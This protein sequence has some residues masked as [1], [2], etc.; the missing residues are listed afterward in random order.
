MVFMRDVELPLIFLGNF[1]QIIMKYNTAEINLFLL[2]V[3]IDKIA[4]SI[5]WMENKLFMDRHKTRSYQI[6]L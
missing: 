5:A 4:F 1:V 3:A 6:L 2:P